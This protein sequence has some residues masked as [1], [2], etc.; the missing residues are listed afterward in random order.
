MAGFLASLAVCGDGVEFAWPWALPGTEGFLFFIWSKSGQG[1]G[2][3]DS[4]SGSVSRVPPAHWLP[5]TSSFLGVCGLAAP[6]G[7]Q[8]VPSR[9]GALGFPGIY[10]GDSCHPRKTP[11]LAARVSPRL[12]P[13]H[14]PRVERE[15]S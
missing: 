8:C 15:K 3:F 2:D 1:A 12:C 14:T 7:D 5:A 9:Q 4:F 10:Q 13:L 11:L 6:A